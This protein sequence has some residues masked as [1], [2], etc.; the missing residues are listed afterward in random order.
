MKTLLWRTVHLLALA[1]LAISQPLLGILGEN[2]TFFTAHSSSPGQTVVFAITVALAPA[3]V[4]SALMLAGHALSDRLGEVVFLGAAAALTF[5]F[6]IQV[7][8][9]IGGSAWLVATIAGTCACGLM[10]LYLRHDRVRSV[11]SVLSV[12]APFVV[13]YFLFFSA[14]KSVV[15]PDDIEA[16]TLETLLGTDL[17]ILGDDREESSGAESPSADAGAGRNDSDD[18]AANRSP[19]GSSVAASAT[20]TTDSDDTAANRSPAG[21]V[22]LVERLNERFPP[23]HLLVFDELPWHSL[24]DETGRIDP[25]R[26]P[27]FARLGETSHVFENATTVAFTTESAVP[28]LLASTLDTQPAP[29]YSMYP[30]NLFTLLGGVYDV[31][32]WDPLVDLCPDSVCDGSPP[33]QILDWITADDPASA[34]TSPSSTAAA[35]APTTFSTTSTASTTTPPTTTTAAAPA[36]S[37]DGTDPSNT[38]RAR[39]HGPANGTAP[40][41]DGT[42]PSNTRRARI[43]GPADGAAPSSNGADPSSKGSLAL[44]FEDAAIVFGH[45]V[46]PQGTDLGL[47]SIGAGWGNF[48]GEL[49]TTA[50]PATTPAPEPATTS[51]STTTT[52]GTTPTI[53]T[54]TTASTTTRP[55]TTTTAGTTTRP[56]TTTAPTPTSTTTG[57][58]QARNA[59]TT[60]LLDTTALETGVDTER[61]DPARIAEERTAFLDSLIYLDTRVLDYRREVAAIGPSS[62]PRLH[63]LHGLLPHVPWRLRP[64]GSLY[65]DISLPGYF[66]K[67]DDDET[68]AAFGQQRHLLQLGFVDQLLGEYLDRLEAVGDFD[69]AMVIVTADHGVSFVAGERS[70]GLGDMNVGGIAG[71]PLLFKEP[72]QTTGTV[73][74]RPV[75]L[76]DIVPTIAAQLKVDAPWDF[77]G[78]DMFNGQPTAEREVD[79]IGG[80]VR[81]PEDF[82]TVTDGLAA[83][84]HAVFGDGKSGSLYGLGGAH[85]LI[86]AAARDSTTRRSTHCW[87]KERPSAVPEP[88]GA[89]GYVFGH[90][91]APA[92]A[93]ISFA[94]V[95]DGI[96]AGTARS[97][98]DGPA[99]RVFAIGD[100]QYWT[101]E[102]PVVELRE[103]IESRLALIPNC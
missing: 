60:T 16:V 2:P 58:S 34:A 33:E 50:V 72:H 48:G 28:A 11:V 90:I 45:L 55:G 39:I 43:H 82:T 64:D 77:A 59:P 47:P 83:D 19:A 84:M 71:I 29:V 53:G 26:Y 3:L 102:E 81:V 22:S 12:L 30:Q 49:T 18:T 69:R 103:I 95:V 78:R 40:S 36:P 80:S 46:A 5:L 62:L 67:W 14:A 79:G 37:N 100:S 20:S 7:V 97:F 87:V 25:A 65:A 57:P 1:T 70:R 98:E 23:I 75:Q 24:L 86:G 44:L 51:P 6:L 38:R 68:K 13:V 42:D 92:G 101:G 8:D 41:N 54:T 89:I 56:G 63:Y 32:A 21:E 15:F 17:D 35:P 31:S 52:I 4:L 96:V 93:P 9:V 94:V 66:S 74:S 27:N 10:T 88:D 76:I 61:I 91:D 73:Q 85:S 99:H